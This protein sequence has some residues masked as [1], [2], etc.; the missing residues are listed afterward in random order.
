MNPVTKAGRKFS[1][2]P[3]V[4]TGR[5]PKKRGRASRAL[6][7]GEAVPQGRRPAPGLIV[8]HTS[9]GDEVRLVDYFASVLLHR[10]LRA[11]AATSDLALG[12]L[13]LGEALELVVLYA[14]VEPAVF[15]LAPRYWS[16]QVE[17]ER[18]SGLCESAPKW[19]YGV[20]WKSFGPSVS[21]S[22][23]FCWIWRTTPR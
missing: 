13:S 4:F 1:V 3:G 20:V 2:R 8:A 6:R 23:P 12:T 9:V 16:A 10:S 7:K 17:E 5:D 18:T 15:E 22:T 19:S 14:E 21:R 11:F